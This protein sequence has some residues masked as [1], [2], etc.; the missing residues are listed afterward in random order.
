MQNYLNHHPIIETKVIASIINL[1]F[2]ILEIQNYQSS[3]IIDFCSHILI[4]PTLVKDLNDSLQRATAAAAATA[5]NN[6]NNN[7]NNELTKLLVEKLKEND[8][9]SRIFSTFSTSEMANVFLN[10]KDLNQSIC[11]LANLCSLAKMDMQSL[12]LNIEIFIVI[13]LHIFEHCSELLVNKKRNSKLDPIA[14]N[15]EA[16]PT[17]T[18][19]YHPLFGYLKLKSSHK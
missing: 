1:S 8:L 6:S 15:N 18:I 3:T 9:S 14:N 5:T 10:D 2:R 12:K 16:N 7:N 17:G 11:F 19:S 13:C 4:I